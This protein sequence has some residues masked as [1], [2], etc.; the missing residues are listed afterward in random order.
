MR[1]PSPA[2]SAHDKASAPQTASFPAP[3]GKSFMTF[4]QSLTAAARLT[5]A[6]LDVIL[7]EKWMSGEAPEPQAGRLIAAMRHA[8]L[9]GGKRVRPLLV[10]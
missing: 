7:A 3:L 2:A 10:I 6:T 5:E 4:A 8:V 9:S 1:T